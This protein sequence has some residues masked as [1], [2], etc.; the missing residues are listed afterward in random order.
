MIPDLSS[1]SLSTSAKR[2]AEGVEK[3]ENG[4]FFTDVLSLLRTTHRDAML[5]INELH[6]MVPRTGP[7]EDEAQQKQAEARA[8][9]PGSP[10]RFE[11]LMKEVKQ[12]ANEIQAMRESCPKEARRIQ[13]LFGY[14]GSNVY[15][16]DTT[17]FEEA[18]VRVAG[19]LMKKKMEGLKREKEEN[20][21][22]RANNTER[23]KVLKEAFKNLPTPPVTEEDGRVADEW[24]L[25]LKKGKADLAR[26]K[27]LEAEMALLAA[28]PVEPP[29]MTQ[30]AAA[31]PKFLERSRIP[32][33]VHPADRFLAVYEA[34]ASGAGLKWMYDFETRRLISDLVAP[35][36]F[37]NI[38]V[39]QNGRLH[40]FIIQHPDQDKAVKALAL[41][42]ALSVVQSMV[43][44]AGGIRSSPKEDAPLGLVGWDIRLD[45]SPPWV[46]D[47]LRAFAENKALQEQGLAS[48]AE[49]ILGGERTRLLTRVFRE[50]KMGNMGPVNRLCLEFD[51]GGQNCL[52]WAEMVKA[53][54]VPGSPM[55]LVF[56]QVLDSR[57]K[58][59]E[60]TVAAF[61]ASEAKVALTAW[62]RHA[63]IL[64]KGPSQ[65]LMVDPWKQPGEARVPATIGGLFS[66]EWVERAPE[67][68]NESSCTLVSLTRALYLS[69]EI[70]TNGWNQGVVRAAATSEADKTPFVLT[71]SA[72]VL[73]AESSFRSSFKSASGDAR[74]HPRL[75]ELFLQ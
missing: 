40:F 35:V 21:K 51:R 10:E 1:L 11:E 68:C 75:G 61:F 46:A 38:R 9:G 34:K 26:S 42:A 72:L 41:A 55:A 66:P 17:T 59:F 74:A 25:L 71:C 29:P 52:R 23:G 36:D 63:R 53:L 47:L 16:P 49:R 20:A 5:E 67:Q 15:S 27:E 50:Q 12:I 69:S 54:R 44:S 24:N 14:L 58:D 62:G 7:K 22:K 18:A 6:A 64:V 70:Q 2:T 28:K 3:N 60:Q 57:H 45:F 8:L 48:A 31:W 56:E 73:L 43:H 65:N 13:R 33:F 19:R 30:W 4:M 32:L 39:Q 37:R